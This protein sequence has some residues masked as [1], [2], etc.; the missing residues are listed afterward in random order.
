MAAR[1]PLTRQES[2][3]RTRERL[4]AAAER[5]FLA[6]GYHA[7][8]VSQLA[9]A[10]GYTTGALY[11]NFDGKEGLALA[12][13][14]RRMVAIVGALGQRL[15]AAPTTVAG[16]LA[17][18]A[19][20]WHDL[21]GD[22]PWAVLAAEFALAT[23]HNPDLRRQFQLRLGAARQAIALLLADQCR[24]VGFHPHL[25]P[26]RLAETALALGI[27]LSVLRIADPKADPGVFSEA[28]A[29]LLDSPPHRSEA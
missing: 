21:L 19:S 10:A 20:L 4:I 24:T 8:S 6:K 28:M 25:P 23:R 29:F 16:R 3:A 22:E 1:Q 18:V 12:V 14:E 2:Q 9:R 5:V 13:L 7:A 26:A 27:G 11:S 17:A 15:Q